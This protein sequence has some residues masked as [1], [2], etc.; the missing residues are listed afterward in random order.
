MV[1]P[2]R[3]FLCLILLF[4]MLSGLLGS[5]VV[6]A[7]QEG[8]NGSLSLPPSQEEPPPEEPPETNLKSRLKQSLRLFLGIQ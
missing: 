8:I 3:H 1:R 2:T 5:Q 4:A 6:L 7:A